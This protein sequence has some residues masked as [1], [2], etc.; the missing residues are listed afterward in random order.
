M[1]ENKEKKNVFKE[2]LGKV[3]EFFKNIPDGFTRLKEN[4]KN[5][6]KKNKIILGVVTGVILIALIV[7]IIILVIGTRYGNT[8][9]NTN[10]HG[11]VA[12][13]GSKV[14]IS[15]I[16]TIESDE[17]SEN[18]QRSGVYSISSNGTV[19]TYETFTDNIYAYSINRI[20]NWVY[21]MKVD[22][23]NGTRDI[24]KTNGKDRIVL[25]DNMSSYSNDAGETEYLLENYDLMT[26]VDDYVYYINENLN[27]SRIKT[28]GKDREV[29]KDDI[30]VSDFQVYDGYIYINNTD[31]EFIKIN[32]KDFEDRVVLTNINANDFQVD[33]DYIYYIDKSDKLVRTNLNGEEETVIVDKVVKSFNVVKNDIYY[34]SDYEGDNEEGEAGVAN[35]YAI[36]RL[37][38]KK[39]E[40][41]KIVETEVA[42]SNI[43]VVGDYIYYEDK[44]E[45][46]YYYST[47]Y[48]IKTDGTEK[49][50]LSSKV[51]SAEVKE[52]DVESQESSN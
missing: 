8:L 52:Y 21:Y 4:I 1:S 5:L 17:V 28:N 47:I 3:K 45:D 29:I 31:N 51:S 32:L 2:A 20:G 14:I 40:T 11:L 48:K 42:Y 15:Y 49:E 46:D 37:D 38:T 27:L 34:F 23:I 44:F 9:G 41:S 24:V 30:E 13:D 35:S 12:K 50:D 6:E 18:Y 25:V 26:V 16:N 10:N 19:K 33:D 39:N 22:E 7:I 36:F 43:S